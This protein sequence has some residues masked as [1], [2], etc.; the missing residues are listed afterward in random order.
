MIQQKNERNNDKQSSDN[1]VKV[2]L[3]K[4]TNSKFKGT[5]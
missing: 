1:S 3:S 5:N 2:K 4:L